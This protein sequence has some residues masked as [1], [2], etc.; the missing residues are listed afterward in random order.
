MQ[1][2]SPKNL[3]EKRIQLRE[4]IFGTE[5]ITGKT[6]DLVLIFSIIIS[7]TVVMLDSVNTFKDQ[8][9][10]LLFA[11][12]WFF[13]IL[14]TIEYSL[15]LICIRAPLRYA[16]SFFGIIDLLAIIPTYLSLFLPGTHFLIVIRL[17]RVLRIFRILKLVKYVGEAELLIQSL[18]ASSRKIT[19]FFFTILNLMTVFGSLIY[20]IEGEENGFT[21]IP[22]SI[23]WAIVTMTTVGYGDISP[24]TNTGQT[25]AAIIMVIGYSIIAVPTG[26]VTA[27]LTKQNCHELNNC[28]CPECGASDHDAEAAFCYHCGEKLA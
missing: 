18:K 12:E 8:Y 6:F 26:I 28:S 15:R 11:L 5:T 13:T 20:V 9:G 22:K 21:S 1:F 24:Q 17:L 3:R 10:Y 2:F 27:E 16:T 4:L 19:I 23:Y 25:L 7:V 14:F